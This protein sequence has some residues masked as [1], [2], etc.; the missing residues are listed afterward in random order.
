MTRAVTWG[1]GPAGGQAIRNARN[2][3]QSSALYMAEE[4]FGKSMK[5]YTELKTLKQLGMLQE[6]TTNRKKT[7]NWTHL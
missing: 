6:M 3:Q 2:L 4:R 7:W 5:L 1:E